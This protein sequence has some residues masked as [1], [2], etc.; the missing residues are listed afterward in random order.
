VAFVRSLLLHVPPPAS[1]RVVVLLIQTPVEPL[2][3]EGI[4]FT[5]AIAVA[6]QPGPAA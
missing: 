3:V 6:K 5:V 2:I 4:G 1:E